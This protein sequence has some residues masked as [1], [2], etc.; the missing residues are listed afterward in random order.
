[1]RSNYRTAY[2]VLVRPKGSQLPLELSQ[3]LV[4]DNYLSGLFGGISLAQ[5]RR[6]EKLP[7]VEVA[8]PI[9]NVGYV[10][11][12]GQKDF[13]V[14]DLLDR[15]GVQLYRYTAESVA[16]RGESRYPL[17]TGYIYYTRRD[18]FA[19]ASGPGSDFGEV[20]PGRADPLK[21]CNPPAALPKEGPFQSPPASISCVSARSP[22]YGSDRVHP[23]VVDLDAGIYFPI[24][25]AAIDPVQE[26]KLLGL[27]R[28]IVSGRYLREGEKF[29]L[30]SGGSNFYQ[31]LVPVL[32]SS[33]TYVDEHVAVRIER[34]KIP[35]HTN[36]PQRLASSSTAF[37]SKLRGR[38]VAMRSIS[39]ASMYAGALAGA[40]GPNGRSGQ[41]SISWLY[42]T[43][44]PVRYGASRR[45][46]V[47][48]AVTNAQSV[49]RTTLA[50]GGTAYADV[51]QAN[52]DVQFRQLHTRRGSG[53][54]SSY[55]VPGKQILDT[56]TMHF[57]GRYDP[58]RL[59]GF[60]PLSKVPL[61]TYY[62]PE[63]QAADAKSKQALEGK[64]LLP[65]EN[66]ADYVAQPPL[67]L[68]TLQGMQPF[69]NPKY[70]AGASPKRPISVIRV[71]VKGVTGP[72]ALSQARIRQVASEIH[73]ATG[74]QVDI[75]AGSSPRKLLV[76][77]PAG[78]FGRPPL[79]LQ[80]GWS[81]KG[82]SVSFLKALDKK[83]LG[84][85][86]LVLVSCLFFLANGA[87]ASVRG[88]RTEIGTLLCLGWS[89]RAIFAAVLAE[90]CLVG[91]V[92]G[93]A[94]V[95][96]AYGIAHAFSLELGL[97]RALLVAPLA[98]LLAL[99]AGII[100]AWRAAQ[101][102]PLDAVRPSV[103]TGCVRRQVRS[104]RALALSNVRR[105][106]ARSLVGAGALFIGVAALTLL[107][108]VN[109][110]F[111]GQV[112]GTLL[113]DAISYQV[114]GLDFLAVGL[115]V[116]LAC[117][118][119]ADVLYLNLRERAGELVT[120]RTVGWNDTQLARVI[121]GE[122]LC[123]GLL[124]S[125]PG[126]ALA[127][128]I[129]AELGAGLGPLALGALAG[130]AGGLAVSLLASLLPLLRLRAL[131]VPSVLAEE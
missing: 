51:A 78:K 118:S 80:E 79:L 65:S 75:T 87:F 98:L 120:L 62:P 54:Y 68:T 55:D 36:V 67:F 48:Q 73:D 128:A 24:L 60:S 81:K 116:V 9:A 29:R 20:I 33:R 22:G 96:L 117:L 110:A 10:M 125:V 46:L 31:R 18:R 57:V 17:R 102:V 101:T 7:G 42:W 92:A 28:T 56:P 43:A 122:A 3:G 95:A 59:P 70:Y 114:R 13:S 97:G 82:V 12:L 37:L 34:L 8:A 64:P 121:A 38:T 25:L 14:K 16:Q 69:L 108:A 84:L 74:L 72:N 76:S 105:M 27:D 94:G 52:A 86:S 50:S 44:S 83:R 90:L 130:I 11:P 100:P 41:R 15:S 23:G 91:L 124:G 93:L 47:P 53:V 88:R 129:G 119:L 4:R 77:L 6:I 85:I 89:Q 21:V 5:W 66:I 71:R 39:A 112:V 32:A 111:R 103:S 113:G 40:F 19:F 26:A 1:V 61:E 30:E 49:W 115:I 131:T 104:L 123:L 58:S 109:E 126:A 45:T 99:L 106:P 35:P 127:F 107:L 63:L 2:D